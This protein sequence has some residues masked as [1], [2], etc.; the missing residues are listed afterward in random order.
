MG[1][2]EVMNDVRGWEGG[3]FRHSDFLL[4]SLFL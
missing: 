1:I 2:V 3:V 4:L